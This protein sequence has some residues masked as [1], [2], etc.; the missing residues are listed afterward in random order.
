MDIGCYCINVSRMLFGSEPDDVQSVVYRSPDFETD[1]LTS[2]LLR[3][4][5]GQATFTCSTAMED[6]QR[7][8]VF[9][10]EGRLD[11][12]IPFNARPGVRQRIFLTQGGDPP[13]RPDVETIETEAA[14]Q[15]T[16]QGD[17]FAAAVLDDED[18][19]VPNADSVANMRVIEAVLE[20]RSNA[21]G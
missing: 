3:F 7:V 17:A 21:P 10:T 5:E 2:G 6:Y 1:V 4:G 12:E 16:L 13:A 8:H 9:A 19:P 18:V 14:N 11:V 20:G 15:Y